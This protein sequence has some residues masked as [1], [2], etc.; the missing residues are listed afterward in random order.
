[1]KTPPAASIRLGASVYYRTAVSLFAILLVASIILF[2]RTSGDFGIKIVFVGLTGALAI[3]LG[4][5]DAWRP[6]QGALHYA[7]GQW[8]LA[9]GDVESQGTLQV[10]SD[11][12][13]YILARYTPSNHALD[14]S[15]Q[16]HKTQWL[17]LES[18]H[19][20]DWRALRR[21]LF[22]MPLPA[23]TIP[24]AKPL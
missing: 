11:L 14:D 2:T 7:A 17:H 21:A 16:Q 13:T 6:R 9:K 10:V 24:S 8:V 19:G 12:Q 20:Q 18:R 22:A 1:M 23:M 3:A 4:L 15:L 5:W